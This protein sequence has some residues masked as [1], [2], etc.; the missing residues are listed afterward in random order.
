MSFLSPA[1]KDGSRGWQCPADAV[2]PIVSFPSADAG[3]AQECSRCGAP[4]SLNRDDCRY[5]RLPYPA[6]LHQFVAE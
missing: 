2:Y 5:C 4:V 1:F 3:E 6:H